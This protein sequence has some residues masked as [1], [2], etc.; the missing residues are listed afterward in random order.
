M[1]KCKFGA[2]V[3]GVHLR[4]E[5]IDLGSAKPDHSPQQPAR[6]CTCCGFL[7]FVIRARRERNREI[8]ATNRKTSSCDSEQERTARKHGE[9]D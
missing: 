1:E 3:N 5:R 4:D 6:G 8:N 9:K 7:F 2:F